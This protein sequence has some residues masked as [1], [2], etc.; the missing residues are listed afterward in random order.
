M[1][2]FRKL[3]P[4]NQK[5]KPSEDIVRGVQGVLQDLVDERASLLKNSIRLPGMVVENAVNYAERMGYNFNTGDGYTSELSYF[6]KEVGTLVNRLQAKCADIAYEKII[7]TYKLEGNVYPLLIYDAINTTIFMEPWIDWLNFTGVVN[8]DAELIDRGYN[9][10][11]SNPSFPIDPADI[12]DRDQDD[13]GNLLI[14]TSVDYLDTPFPY[15]GISTRHLLVS[16]EPL[17]RKSDG[18]RVAEGYNYVMSNDTAKSFYSNVGQFK[19]LIEIA[20][21][22]FRLKMTVTTAGSN[23]VIDYIDESGNAHSPA[24]QMTSRLF[25][26]RDMATIEKIQFGSGRH[27]DA[28]ITAETITGCQTPIDTTSTGVV[29][30]G[31]PNFRTTLLDYNLSTLSTDLVQLRN[32]ITV[33]MKWFNF[34]E[35]CFLDSSNNVVVYSKFP[36]IKFYP[37]MYSS[38]YLEVVKV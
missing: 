30:D 20:H 14:G 13:F 11:G 16:Y 5:G 38:V 1:I 18:K 12:L 6:R 26:G 31:S 24:V 15:Y 28:D 23:Y 10:D 37:E 3:L 35:I 7:Y 36:E 21:F 19:R 27:T 2:D 34:T 29:N 25:T 17:M 22:E 32:Y 4:S 33:A 9:D 8:E